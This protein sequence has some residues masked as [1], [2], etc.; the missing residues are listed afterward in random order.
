MIQFNRDI[1]PILSDACYQCHGPDKATRKAKLR[2][3]TEEGAYADRNGSRAIVPGRPEESEVLK[4]LTTHDPDEVMPPADSPKKLKP[5]QILLIKE[6]IKQGAKYEGHWA[7]IPP[8]KSAIP[9]VDNASWV[10]NPIDSFILARLEKEKISPS[11]PAD[12]R[13]LIR[14]LSFDLRGLP[15]SPA[16]VESFIK[17]RRPNAYDLLVEKFLSS[18][19]YG[20][21]MAMHW[22]DLVR[23]ADTVGY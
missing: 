1:R 18:A 14:R 23:Y 19:H 20:E 13:T 2:L 6:W 15:P 4:R 17:D 22:L 10:V 21:R 3:D 12:K 7:Y 9:R 5:E 11:K 16:E 8:V